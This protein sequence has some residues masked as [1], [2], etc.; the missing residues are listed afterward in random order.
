MSYKASLGCASAFAAVATFAG[1]AFAADLAP[2]PP[3]PPPFTWTGVYLGG[4][5]GG[6]WGNDNYYYNTFDPISGL[7]S[8]P[9][10]SIAPSGVI[11]GAHAGFNYQIDKP[12]GGFVI[13]VEGS[14]DGL[15]LS[16]TVSTPYAAFGGGSVSASTN[17]EIQGSI[18]GRFGIAWDRLLAYATG[19]VAFGGFNT[20]YS[21]VGNSSGALPGGAFF[22]S[23]SFSNSRVGWTAGGGIKYAVTNNWSVFAEYRYTS[24]GTVGNTFLGSAVFSTVPGLAS[25]A[26]FS[27]HTLNQSQVQVG[28]SYKFDTPLPAPD[29]SI[30]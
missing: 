24:F 11:G 5:I 16:K 7:V 17:T 21:F 23:N 4:Q 29:F 2:A 26:L 9:D 25:G 30:F 19:G 15:S 8:N 18:R 14:V 22:G 20:N 6:A 28:F 12:N 3:P 13:G 10:A 1:S 27:N